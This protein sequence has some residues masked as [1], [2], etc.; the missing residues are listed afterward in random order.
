MPCKLDVHFVPQSIFTHLPVHVLQAGG[1][2]GGHY[3][4][5]LTPENNETLE[6]L[7][8]QAVAAEG[9]QEQECIVSVPFGRKLKVEYPPSA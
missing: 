3:L 7:W 2:L 4:C 1:K 8:Q 5:P 9:V 6:Q